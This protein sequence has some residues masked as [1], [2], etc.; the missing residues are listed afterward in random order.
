MRL[1][2]LFFLL[3]SLSCSPVDR[4]EAGADAGVGPGDKL[5]I[6]ADCDDDAACESDQCMIDGDD[7]YCSDSCTTDADCAPNLVCGPGG[8]CIRPQCDFGATRCAVGGAMERCEQGL[9]VE[10]LCEP[11]GTICTRGACRPACG[12]G[13]I[14]CTDAG[15]EVGC[16]PDGYLND[17]V[18]C[19]AEHA[20]VDG[21][22]CLPVICQPDVSV[23][24]GW[25][26]YRRCVEQGTRL[27]DRTCHGTDRCEDGECLLSV[28]VPGETGCD[29]NGAIVACN[30][31][32]TMWVVVDTCAAGADFAACYNGECRSACD[33]AE[34]EDAYLGCRFSPRLVASRFANPK[35]FAVIVSNTDDDRT[36]HVSLTYRSGGQV[37][38]ADVAP[39]GVH[40]FVD[41]GRTQHQAGGGFG[42]QGYNLTSNLP[43][44]AYQFNPLD[45]LG[46]ASTDASLLLPDHV[47][48]K[49]YY[50]VSWPR[51]I[52]ESATLIYA[53]EDGTSLEI[54]PGPN[55]AVG[56][57]GGAPA[58]V[59]GQVT[60]T[61]LNASQSLQFLADGDMTGTRIVSDKPIGVFA[62]SPCANVP[63]NVRYCDHLEEQMLPQETW[64]STMVVAP[65]FARGQEPSIFRVIAEQDGTELSFNPAIV[66]ADN[67]LDAGEFLEFESAEAFVLTANHPILLIQ[68][69]VG[70]QHPGVQNGGARN[71][72]D[73]AMTTIVPAGQW[74]HDYAYLIPET[75]TVNYVTITAPL[76]TDV[77]LDGEMLSPDG[78]T[79]IDESYQYRIELVS[80]GAHFLEASAPVAIN[81]HGY[82]GGP[83]AQASVQN[84]SYAYPGGLDLNIINPKD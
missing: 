3:G 1:L 36:A 5:G 23:C 45:T 58:L 42:P 16:G 37:F 81:V 62:G 80:T 41:A 43:I 83:G 84:V 28:C 30:D 55:A 21:A 11:A 47:L 54:M 6:G 73:P 71:I 69:M 4:P 50:V 33:I 49:H 9:W 38:E 52:A 27:E 34:A 51:S 63:V 74:R 10:E 77:L 20:C 82:G 22:G 72:G 18:A 46:A 78:W 59:P 67:T 66:V 65:F 40:A 19:Q 75:Y 70:S 79:V 44:T 68:F 53:I 48:G 57:V 26:T 60:N 15:E 25:N 29:E 24:T 35:D 8:L 31:E 7:R 13:D 32:G 56:A 76:A 17:P 61:T 64:G 14:V 2:A 39:G 12:Q